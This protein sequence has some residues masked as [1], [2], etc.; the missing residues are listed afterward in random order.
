MNEYER[1]GDY[2]QQTQETP[3]GL[4]VGNAVKFLLIGMGIGAATALLLSPKSGNE[5][6]RAR[7]LRR[8]GRN[9]GNGATLLVARDGDE[10]HRSHERLGFPRDLI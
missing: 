3:T 10:F 1:Y 8:S 7:E 9:L 4:K 2:T 5:I 6:R